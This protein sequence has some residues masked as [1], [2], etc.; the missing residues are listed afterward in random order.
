[1]VAITI[2]ILYTYYTH[3]ING[4]LSFY[5]CVWETPIVAEDLEQLGI[6]TEAEWSGDSKNEASPNSQLH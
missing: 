5:I 3:I 2:H 4:S 6:F 1:M